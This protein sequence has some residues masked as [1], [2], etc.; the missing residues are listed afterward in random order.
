MD[1]PDIKDENSQGRLINT[2]FE[3]IFYQSPIGILLYDIKGRLTHANDSALKIARIPQLDDVLGTNLF[4]NPVLASKKEELH[5]KGLINFQDSLDLIKIKEQNIYDPIEPE[6]VDIDWTVSVNDSGYLIQIQDITEQ[7][8]VERENKSLLDNVKSERDMLSALINNIPDEVWFADKNK[9]F[10]LA[11]PSALREFGLYRK[12]IDIEKLASNLDVYRPDGS[13][14]PV[15]EA[16]PLRALNGEHIQN[17]DEI[18]R[19]PASNELRYRQVNASPVKD[20]NNNIIGAVSVVRDITE[21][22]KV[23]E[24]LKKSQKEYINLFE[25]MNEGFTIAEMI[26]NEKGKPFDFRWI[27]MNRA[28]EEIIGYKR[29]TL[30]NTTAR[31]VFPELQPKLVENFGNVMLTGKQLHFENY[32]IELN[33][34]FDVIAYKITEKRFAFLTLDITERKNTEKL[35]QKLL[36]NEQQLTEELQVT[37]E[38]LIKQGDKLLQI[39]SALLESEESFRIIIEN[40]QDAY[41]RADKKGTIIMASPSAARMYRFDSTQEMIGTSTPSYFKNSEDRDFAIEQLKKHGNFK[42]YE[43]EARRN[44]GTFFWVSQNAQYYYDEQ[45]N[46]Q[47]SETFVRD[48]TEKIKSA[49]ELKESEEK[50]RNIVEIANEGIMIADPSGRINF[51]NAKMAEMLGYSSKELLGTN[52]ESLVDKDDRELGLQKIENRKKGIQESYEIKYIRKNGEKLWCLISATPMYDYNGK[53]IGNMTMQTNITE[54]K[55]INDA[56]IESE[57]RFHSVLDNSQD[58]IYRI[59]VQT[60]NYEYVSPSTKNIFGYSPDELM[61]LAATNPLNTIHPDDRIKFQNGLNKLEENDNVEMEY[62][63]QTKN[64]GYR[65]ISNNMGQIRDNNGNPLYR[66]GNMRDIT[67]RKLIEEQ[68]KTTMDELKR[69]NEELE[70]F[71]YVSSHDLQEPLRMVKLYSQLLER[72]YKDNLDSDADDFIKYIVEGSNRMKQLIDDLLEYSR[73]TSQAKEFEDIDLEKVLD[74]VLKNLSISIIEYNVKISHDLLP[75]VFADQNQ[76]LQVFQ[77]LITNA[78]KFQGQNPPEINISVKKGKKEWIFSVSDN[79][80]GIDHKHQNQIFE[81]FKRLHHNRDEYPG[82]GI[83]LSITQKIILHHGGRI[84]VESEPGKG[85]TFYFTIPFKK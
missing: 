27:D 66:D 7:K 81:A 10:T 39:N 60:G 57:S 43:V 1:K 33:A 16:P 19:N 78:I 62:R 55:K 51:V 38:D 36:E 6:I 35:N 30:I 2:N 63:H 13:P 84:W 59:N 80:I 34:W 75:I 68:M 72:R 85:S 9:K 69:S 53:H 82:S 28:Y 18:V 76:I 47:G 71:A 25:R 73:V 14:R 31:T 42:N 46:I 58:V 49:Q 29:D 50:Y 65:W 5:E 24:S 12:D 32:N 15:D 23:E 74:Y 44:D 11:N 21:S 48:I 56:L 41:M 4:D 20:N 70:R 77:N 37:N 26:Y 61:A 22:K 67:N 64:G 79:G 52:A 54:R 3:E 40:I 83:G 17:M 45:G 8:K